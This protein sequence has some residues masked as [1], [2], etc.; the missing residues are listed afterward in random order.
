MSP[1]I[2][3]CWVR[4]EIPRRPPDYNQIAGM[5]RAKE[6]K[7]W[8]DYLMYIMLYCGSARGRVVYAS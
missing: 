5:S 2:P 1:N 3:I 4:M 6:T 7:V 8:A